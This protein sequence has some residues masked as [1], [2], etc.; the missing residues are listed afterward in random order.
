MAK[1]KRNQSREPSR[2][3]RKSSKK[4]KTDTG[5]HRLEYPLHRTDMSYQ[6][7]HETDTGKPAVSGPSTHLREKDFTGEDSD[8]NEDYIA[9]TLSDD[10]TTKSEHESA[11]DKS[12]RR[13][14]DDESNKKSS[15]K[16][17]PDET[18]KR[19]IDDGQARPW[20]KDFRY[21][22][23][24]N[25][26]ERLNMEMTDLVE[27][28][29][30]TEEEHTMRR[31]AVHRIRQCAQSV[32]PSCTIEVFGSFETKLYLPTSDIDLVLFY[33]GKDARDTTRV[34]S[35]LAD[36]LRKQ[37]IAYTVQVIAKARVSH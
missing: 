12:S 29:S 35:R 2:E 37:G 32:Y 9:F 20:A 21:R 24:R 7:L 34:L 25:I 14:T 31:F 8:I 3:S 36:A 22:K 26:G 27:Y 5:M 6:Y 30:P 17:R 1:R 15:S 4:S 11:Q 18:W 23:A 28:L 16:R 33:E 10:E 13:N 19:Y